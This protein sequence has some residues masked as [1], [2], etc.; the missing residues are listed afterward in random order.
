MAHMRLSALLRASC[1]VGGV[2]CCRLSVA[3]APLPRWSLISGYYFSSAIL[4]VGVC[5]HR[6]A[7]GS[8]VYSNTITIKSA[9]KMRP[10]FFF[11]RSSV[12]LGLLGMPCVC[13]PARSMRG[14][15]VSTRKTKQEKSNGSAGR[16]DVRTCL[17]RS[18]Y[19]T[20]QKYSVQQH[21]TY[22]YEI[23]TVQQ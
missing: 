14:G 11:T 23:L 22:S 21:P 12:H 5:F 10:H 15:G 2:L 13:K 20:I 9:S 4:E 1:A 6:T 18:S 19:C 16:Q 17:Y 3:A 7:V 8:S